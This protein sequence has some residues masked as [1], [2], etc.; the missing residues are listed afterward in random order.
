MVLIILVQVS[1]YDSIVVRTY[2]EEEQT[3]EAKISG[4]R[5]ERAHAYRATVNQ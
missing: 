1:S 3:K 5:I 4:H 2:S